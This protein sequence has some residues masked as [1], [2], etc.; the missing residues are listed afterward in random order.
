MKI[1]QIGRKHQIIDP[2]SSADPCKLTIKPHIQAQFSQVSE[3]Q[4]E[5]E[6][7]EKQSEEKTSHKETVIQIIVDFSTETIAHL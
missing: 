4:Q 7:P 6:N 2:R 1:T 5:R 3:N